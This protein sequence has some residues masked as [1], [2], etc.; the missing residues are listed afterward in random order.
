[1]LLDRAS[2]ALLVWD[3]QKSFYLHLPRVNKKSSTPEIA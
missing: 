3:M 2:V 1:M